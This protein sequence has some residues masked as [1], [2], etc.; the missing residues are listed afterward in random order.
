MMDDGRWMNSVTVC[1][2]DGYQDSQDYDMGEY[3]DDISGRKLDPGL[4]KKA[5]EEDMVEFTNHGVYSKV[6]VHE[7]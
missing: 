6:L 5:R 3:W 1:A 2:V 4:V 7:C